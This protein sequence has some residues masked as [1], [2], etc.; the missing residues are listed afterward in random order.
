MLSVTKRHHRGAIGQR[1]QQRGQ[2]R[3]IY[4]KAPTA[5]QLRAPPDGPQAHLPAPKHRI[6]AAV[7]SNR[8]SSTHF[9]TAY[10]SQLRKHA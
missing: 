8:G 3:S 2:C 10:P 7:L 4:F 9:H 1:S 5:I 6:T